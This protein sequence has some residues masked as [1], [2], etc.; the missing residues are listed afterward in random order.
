[1]LELKCSL[2]VQT[3]GMRMDNKTL[4]SLKF[5]ERSLRDSG[6]VED[7]AFILLFSNHT[8]ILEN[9]ILQFYIC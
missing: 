3:D 5:T 4:L 7:F 2:A 8:T 1:M 9:R 6:L